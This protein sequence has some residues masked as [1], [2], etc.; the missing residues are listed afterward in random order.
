M[1]F[2][3]L[4]LIDVSPTGVQA[5]PFKLMLDGVQIK[6]ITSYTLDRRVGDIASVT[7]TLNVAMK[8]GAV[9]AVD[10][11][12]IGDEARRFVNPGARA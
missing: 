9:E 2:H 8:V 4:E 3:T 5:D 12:S 6:G 10:V 7:I 1:N 11:T